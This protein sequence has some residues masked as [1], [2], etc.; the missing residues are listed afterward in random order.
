MARIIDSTEPLGAYLGGSVAR[1]GLILSDLRGCQLSE[2]RLFKVMLKLPA[3]ALKQ[4]VFG[5]CRQTAEAQ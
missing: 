1:N 5:L 3:Q 2:D 4:R